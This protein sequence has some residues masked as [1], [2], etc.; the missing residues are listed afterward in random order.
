MEL[1]GSKKEGG[2][3]LFK[4]P[5]EIRNELG[6][7]QKEFSTMVCSSFRTY[8]ERISLDLPKWNIYELS[9]LCELNKGKVKVTTNEGNYEVTIKKLG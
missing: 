1:K 2:I 7:T 8:K 4:T 9:K 5:E 3:E 6:V